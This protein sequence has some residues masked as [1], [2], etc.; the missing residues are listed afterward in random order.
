[1]ACHPAVA[2]VIVWLFTP[3]VVS[4][5]R[6]HAV[7]GPSTFVSPSLPLVF[8]APD[9][10]ALDGKQLC[11]CIK[12]LSVLWHPLGVGC[13]EH[14]RLLEPA[15]Q[16]SWH[17][18]NVSQ[19]ARILENRRV[20]FLGDSILVQEVQQLA[21][22]LEQSGQPYTLDFDQ[23][24]RKGHAKDMYALFH[25]QTH[26][27]TL[28]FIGGGL[29]W[30]FAGKRPY[31]LANEVRQVVKTLGQRDVLEINSGVH[32]NL[33]SDILNNSVAVAHG[34]AATM[35]KNAKGPVVLWRET[36]PQHFQSSNGM[37]PGRGFGKPGRCSAMTP[38]M[39]LGKGLKG[40]CRPECT[41]ANIRNELT[42]PVL[43]ESSVPILK[44]WQGLVPFYDQH[45]YAGDCTHWSR[46]VV[47]FLIETFLNGLEAVE[48]SRRHAV[49]Q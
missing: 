28:E 11:E 2:N 42:N 10:D 27:T 39:L 5:L 41:H 49:S 24:H 12:K 44:V 15:S 22:L 21:C 29:Q 26:N 17:R 13:P 46:S 34:V 36:T 45:L 3:A 33:E 16:S 14:S 18:H 4:A 23:P 48:S 30:E 47:H 6:L 37:Y 38:E 40:A 1:M 20:V 43:A 35:P 25:F 9:N 8:S 31:N 19:I 7:G 32:E